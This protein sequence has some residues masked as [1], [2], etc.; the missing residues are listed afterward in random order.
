ME[1]V[2]VGKI[3]GVLFSLKNMPKKVLGDEFLGFGFFPIKCAR[4]LYRDK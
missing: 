3:P 1:M 4:C 2:R